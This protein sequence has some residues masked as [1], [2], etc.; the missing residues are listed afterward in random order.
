[1]VIV[2]TVVSILLS[3]TLSDIIPTSKAKKK[4]REAFPEELMRQR[5]LEGQ[6]GN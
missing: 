1:M 3:L 2:A 6:S 4:N 5:N